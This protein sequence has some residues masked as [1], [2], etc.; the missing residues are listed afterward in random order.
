[1]EFP[2]A[3][4][5]ILAAFVTIV[6]T[7]GGFAISPSP[8]YA[9]GSD[10]VMTPNAGGHNWSNG[11]GGISIYL[12]YVTCS[13]NQP[14]YE[15]GVLVPTGKSC[16]P[17]FV[18]ENNSGVRQVLVSPTHIS[19]TDAATGSSTNSSTTGN[20][21]NGKTKNINKS[22]TVPKTGGSWYAEAEF[23]WYEYGDKNKVTTCAT[24]SAAITTTDVTPSDPDPVHTWLWSNATSNGDSY[25]IINPTSDV[26][27]MGQVQ[28]IIGAKHTNWVDFTNTGDESVYVD[29]GWPIWANPDDEY[30]SNFQQTAT[31]DP[32]ETARFRVDDRILYVNLVSGTWTNVHLYWENGDSQNIK[33]GW[34]Y[35]GE[36]THT[37]TWSD[38]IIDVDGVDTPMGSYID[39]NS[40]AEPWQ[41]P[42]FAINDLDTDTVYNWTAL[43]TNTGSESVSLWGQTVPA[44]N[45]HRFAF[46][47]TTPTTPVVETYYQISLQMLWANGETIW[48]GPGIH[49]NT[50]RPSFQWDTTGAVGTESGLLIIDGSVT[51]TPTYG[52]AHGASVGDPVTATIINDSDGD[53][54]VNGVVVHS[55]DSAVVG[56]DDAQ[57]PCYATQE[58]LDDGVQSCDVTITYLRGTG[59]LIIPTQFSVQYS[60][61]NLSIDTSWSLNND[62]TAV[63][64]TIENTGNVDGEL[65]VAEL[66]QAGWTC[67]E[68]SVAVGDSVT[69][70]KP[71][72]YYDGFTET[73]EPSLS[74]STFGL[75]APGSETIDLAPNILWRTVT[76][77]SVGHTAGAV[78]DPV[79][80]ANGDEHLVAGQGT[81]VRDGHTFSGWEMRHV[82]NL[83]LLQPGAIFKMAGQS[84]AA[85]HQPGVA[86]VVTSSIEL[87]AVWTENNVP[88]VPVVQPPETPE[89]VTTPSGAPN[90]GL[91]NTGSGM[92]GSSAPLA[93]LMLFASIG[94]LGA[95]LSPKKRS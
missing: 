72:D 23:C 4:R 77:V 73:V 87:H 82:G 34:Y 47:R 2:K 25:S 55:G 38:A 18:F 42:L 48:T 31:L 39:P 5:S 30:M 64:L 41:W 63:I 13:G 60:A 6:C 40:S 46:V 49:Y 86:I 44:G 35:H 28:G 90:S 37:F 7:I 43:F 52:I 32:G 56:G 19:I 59:D 51:D 95:G 29:L 54:R 16:Q 69:C 26:A 24:A 65:N 45:S 92:D 71:Y 11:T 89:D 81:L 14:I 84:P 94:T 53:I 79:P 50:T 68:T 91:P 12:D 9:A 33:F 62:D 20:V 1:M 58:L 22:F 80:V 78:P 88:P 70:E 57:N 3:I 66:A 74:N 85:T 83:P 27:L 36:V 17:Y 93:L 8:A 10:P 21:D 61:A 76:Y 75:D 15:W 67:L